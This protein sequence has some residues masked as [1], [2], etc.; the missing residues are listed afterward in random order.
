MRNAKKIT[1]ENEIER[2]IQLY[3]EYVAEF[4]ER[5][6][7]WNNHETD[8]CPDGEADWKKISMTGNFDV[9][10]IMFSDKNADIEAFRATL[11]VKDPEYLERLFPCIEIKTYAKFNL[12]LD[13]GLFNKGA[14]Q[15]T[16][17][18]RKDVRWVKIIPIYHGYSE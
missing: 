14:F 8:I 16:P 1:D 4:N 5:D 17:L 12:Y 15:R 10:S 13:S 11:K 6:R 3:N 9:T 7:A 18:E 2:L